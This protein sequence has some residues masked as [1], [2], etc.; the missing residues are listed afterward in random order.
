MAS[1]FKNIRV[2]DLL[3]VPERKTL[4]TPFEVTHHRGWSSAPVTRLVV[5]S[6][7]IELL[8]VLKE[9]FEMTTLVS[10]NVKQTNI[11]S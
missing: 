1:R 10:I 8:K 4:K 6:D 7:E 5:A 2:K 11:W 9:Q 3:A